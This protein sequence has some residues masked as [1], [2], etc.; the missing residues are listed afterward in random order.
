MAC[1]GSMPVVRPPLP[2]SVSSGNKAASPFL[3]SKL[4]IV[5]SSWCCLVARGSALSLRQR[6]KYRRNRRDDRGYSPNHTN[7]GTIRLK[8]ISQCSE[9]AFNILARDALSGFIV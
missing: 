1:D 4:V 5:Q 2:A 6:H 7:S 8:S 9:Y 3:G